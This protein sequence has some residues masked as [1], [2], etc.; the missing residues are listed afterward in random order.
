MKH[1]AGGGNRIEASFLYPTWQL[2]VNINPLHESVVDRID[3]EYAAFYNKFIF[4][5]QQVHM[6]PVEASRASGILIPG[7]GPH[8]P[9]SKTEDIAIPRLESTG[10]D[11][12]V[13]C[14]TPEGDKPEGG[15]PVMIWY[16]GG[17]WVLGDINT[18]NVISTNLCNRGRC[19]VISPDYRLAPEE[20]FPAAVEDSWEAVLWMLGAGKDMLGLNISKIAV[21]GSSAG[22]DLAAIMCQRAVTRGT[23]KF[24]IQL[25]S[26]PV[27]DNTAGPSNNV[28][29]KENEHV[30]ALPYEKMLRYRRH[31]LPDQKDWVNPEA[32]PLFWE[33]GWSALPPAAIVL[34]EL[35]VLRSEGEQFG[36][37]L[38][39]AGI[40]AEIRI[41]KG[42]PHPFI[43]MDGVLEAGREAI[44][45]FCESLHSAVYPPN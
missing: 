28:S 26:V 27:M 20:P 45:F 2:N 11:I 16:H 39:D 43:A 9:V 21:G 32:S 5:K 17:G 30:P 15:W 6:Q 44:T 23:C 34:G 35:D 8:Q 40:R 41:M 37:K 10:P 24:L 25:L 19:V 12:K 7:A 4:D 29:Y 31:Y 18:E 33:G 22:G 36:K 3:A 14:F 38:Q 13:R 1:S 42:Q